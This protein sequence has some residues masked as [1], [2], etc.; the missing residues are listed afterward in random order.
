MYVP[1]DGINAESMTGAVS[2][3]RDAH[4]LLGRL[5]RAT[6]LDDS[7]C[8]TFFAVKWL[9]DRVQAPRNGPICQGLPDH[10]MA[11]RADCPAQP[12]FQAVRCLRGFIGCLLTTST[13]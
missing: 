5:L 2:N 6:R 9:I 1:H 11:V 3:V 7:R 12:R 4:T 10:R 13:M 8:L